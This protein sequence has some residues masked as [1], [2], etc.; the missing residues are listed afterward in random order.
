VIIWS[1]NNPMPESVTDRP[2]E[3][4]E[5]I[6]MLTKSGTKQYWTHRDGIGGTRQRPKADYRW[7]KYGPPDEKAVAKDM[8]G[9]AREGV[10]E[11]RDGEDRRWRDASERQ[12]S[13]VLAEVAIEPAN[14]KVKIRMKIPSPT[15]FLPEIPRA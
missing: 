9:M 12:H 6:L 14:W 7:I 10:W 13:E 4:H 5:Y 3:S 1:K 2:T 15:L 11:E 8:G